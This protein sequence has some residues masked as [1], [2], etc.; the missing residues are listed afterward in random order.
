[1]SIEIVQELQLL[2]HTPEYDSSCNR[3]KTAMI[4][5]GTNETIVADASI[6]NETRIDE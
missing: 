5:S 4:E 2:L 1:M 3:T 6:I